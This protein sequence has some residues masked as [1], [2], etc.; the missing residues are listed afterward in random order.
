[1]NNSLYKSNLILCSCR[2]WWIQTRMRQE[3]PEALDRLNAAEM[4]ATC[5]RETN[6][7]C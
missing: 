1:M 5:T 4:D 3:A 6:G 2:I 7:E